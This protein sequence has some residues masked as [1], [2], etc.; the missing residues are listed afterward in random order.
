MRE[1]SSTVGGVQALLNPCDVLAQISRS[2]EPRP[3]RAGR[4]FAEEGESPKRMRDLTAHLLELPFQ[5]C[6][7]GIRVAGR[8]PGCPG[9][10]RSST[11]RVRSHVGNPGGLSRGPRGRDRGR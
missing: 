8:Q 4:V 11:Q 10:V 9:G 5:L 2:E 7:D 1:E 6:G 3:E